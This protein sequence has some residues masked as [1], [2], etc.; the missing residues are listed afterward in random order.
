M[1]GFRTILFNILGAVLPILELSEFTNLLS[2]DQL[3]IYALGMTIG[4]GILR[5]LTTTAI[6]QSK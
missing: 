5:Y 4:N 3:A 1:K 2:S 6:F